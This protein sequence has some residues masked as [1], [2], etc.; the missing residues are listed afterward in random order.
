MQQQVQENQCQFSMISLYLILIMASGNNFLDK[1]GWAGNRNANPFSVLNV[2]DNADMKKIKKSYRQLSMKHHPD[3]NENGEEMF[4]MIS[5]AYNEL[6]NHR[7]EWDAELCIQRQ[8]IIDQRKQQREKEEI[9]KQRNKREKQMKDEIGKWRRANQKQRRE[10]H[11]QEEMMEQEEAELKVQ[12]DNYR[13]QQREQQEQWQMQW[14]RQQEEEIQ[15][16]RQKQRQSRDYN[17]NNESAFDFY[18]VMGIAMIRRIACGYF[19][20]NSYQDQRR[21][22]HVKV[23]PRGYVETTKNKKNTLGPKWCR[24]KLGTSSITPCSSTK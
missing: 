6:E 10:K 17:Y 16:L 7:R 13:R 24:S 15:A 11:K 21:V 3:R 14:R 18:Y 9:D 1:H 8:N 5:W 22:I 23:L 20:K 12:M 4:K 2:N 19:S